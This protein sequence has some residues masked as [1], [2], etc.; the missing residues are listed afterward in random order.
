MV[1]ILKQDQYVPMSVE[2]Q[3]MII[4]VG[5]QGLLDDLGLEH[6]KEFESAFFAFMDKDYADVGHDIATKKVLEDDTA[7][8]LKEAALKFKEQ[9]KAEKGL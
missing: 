4:Y 1:E 3:V 5:T 8:K 2:H 7:G 6:I 9:F